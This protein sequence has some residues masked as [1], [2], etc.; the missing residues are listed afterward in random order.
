MRRT[1]AGTSDAACVLSVCLGIHKSRRQAP[2]PQPS[3]RH[4]L[5]FATCP[6][7][8]F[9]HALATWFG[10][11]CDCL[12]PEN[13]KVGCFLLHLQLSARQ[14]S[15]LHSSTTT[16]AYLDFALTILLQQLIT[17]HPTTKMLA[18]SILA[19]AASA[20]AVMAQVTIE[21]SSAASVEATTTLSQA[22]PPAATAS[23]DPAPVNSSTRC[24][25]HGQSFRK[26]LT[27]RSQ[28]VPWPAQQL[29][30]DLRW[31]CFAEHL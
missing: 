7:L 9:S 28:L 18:K 31:C 14:L 29:P 4:L 13:K 16:T 3:H 6:R 15:L 2:N 5:L 22:M 21:T 17:S 10:L 24:K 27:S 25:T 8:I 30:S 11:H 1:R 19:L 20:A 26:M 12:A 23:F